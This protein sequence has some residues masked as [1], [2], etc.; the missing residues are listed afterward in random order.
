M[1]LSEFSRGAVEYMSGI[2]SVV[3]TGK[4]TDLSVRGSIHRYQVCRLRSL[5][6]TS[7]RSDGLLSR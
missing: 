2:P 6:F 1:L 4:A 5:Q 3:R 7:L